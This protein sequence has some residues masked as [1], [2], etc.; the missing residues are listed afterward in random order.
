MKK[1][2]NTGMTLAQARNIFFEAVKGK[3]PEEVQQILKEYREVVPVITEK[4]LR[5]N[6]GWLTSDPLE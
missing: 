6:E 4:E 1:L 3:Q 2:F 5:E